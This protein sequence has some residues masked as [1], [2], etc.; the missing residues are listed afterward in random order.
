MNSGAGGGAANRSG[1]ATS[2]GAACPAC[3]PCRPWC[4]RNRSGRRNR[5]VSPCRPACPPRACAGR[6]PS[7][8]AWPSAAAG[9]GDG[10]R[11]RELLTVRPRTMPMKSSTRSVVSSSGQDSATRDSGASVDR[12]VGEV[13]AVVQTGERLR[14]D[15]QPHSCRHQFDGVRRRGGA[16]VR[17]PARRA[18]PVEGVVEGVQHD[19]VGQIL[20]GHLL[21][22]RHD[23]VLGDHDHRRLG[24]EGDRAEVRTGRP[25]AARSPRRRRRPAAGRTP[26]RRTPATRVSGTSGSRSFQIRTHLVG[27]TPGT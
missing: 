12:P 5:R 20:R 6:R 1:G 11:P 25:A 15:E 4:R 2:D 22:R 9:A 17:G 10:R 21:D 16:L 24:V 13:L 8:D 14:D 27:V 26:R 19:L 7:P 23:V 18:L 3:R